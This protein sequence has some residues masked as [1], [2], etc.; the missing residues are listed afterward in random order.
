MDI[1]SACVSLYTVR[2]FLRAGQRESSSK[3]GS[4]WL[5]VVALPASTRVFQDSGLGRHPSS[6]LVFS[7]LGKLNDFLSTLHVL[8]DSRLGAL[9][10]ALENGGE[11]E[12]E[13]NEEG[14]RSLGITH[15]GGDWTG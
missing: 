9:R 1:C 8:D 6:D 13:I 15:A 4:V 11:F 14:M 7:N 12:T 10:L 3:R 2:F 5:D